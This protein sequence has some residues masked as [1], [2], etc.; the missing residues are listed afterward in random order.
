MPVPTRYQ[1]DVNPARAGMIRP[2]A[3]RTGSAL[4]KPRASGDDPTFV[5][6]VQNAWAVNPA[7]AGMI[8]QTRR[9]RR[10]RRRKPRASGDDPTTRTRFI[11]KRA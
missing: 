10:V 4:R 6:T 8:R 2:L 5:V 7:R 1:D 11:D 3:P 9:S